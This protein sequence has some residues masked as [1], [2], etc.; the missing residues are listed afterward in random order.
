MPDEMT[1]PLPRRAYVLAQ[2]IVQDGLPRAA[3][4]IVMLTDAQAERLMASGHIAP[5][6]S[7]APVGD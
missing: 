7:P 3:G 1:E 6:G 2:P 5:A 4:E